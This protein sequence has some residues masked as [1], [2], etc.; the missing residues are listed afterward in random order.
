M[1]QKPLVKYGLIFALSM[2]LSSCGYPRIMRFPFDN[3]GRGL[4]TS[5]SEFDP[6]VV[7]NFIV[8]VSDRNGSQDVYLYDAQNLKLIETPGLN[9]LDEIANHPS[10][11][12]DGRYIVFEASRQGRSNI[13]LY[14]R[15]TQQKRNL[16]EG[17]N[18]EVRNPTISADGNI[19]AFELAIDGQWDLNVYNRA[20]QEI[21]L[22]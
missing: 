1:R 17:I 3:G 22:P 11:S 13:Y 7:G 2:I 12:E 18:G 8:F 9:A 15:E 19:I 6:Q 4:N 20:G 21:P 14:D 10:V 5:A 16:T